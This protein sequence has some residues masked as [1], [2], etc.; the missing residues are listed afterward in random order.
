MNWESVTLDW[1]MFEQLTAARSNFPST[2]CVYVQ[3]DPARNPLR[4]SKA[5]EGLEV[6]YRGGNGYALN[7]AMHGSRNL[8]FVAAVP[9]ELCEAIEGELIWQGRRGMPYNNNGKRTPPLR[10]LRLVRTGI[11]PRFDGF[12]VDDS[13]GTEERPA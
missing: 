5:S 11:A 12:E 9:K 4:I 7:A 3:A 1:Y 8:V 13:A 10:R 6:R 2:P